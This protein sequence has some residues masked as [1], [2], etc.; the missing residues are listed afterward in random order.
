MENLCFKIDGIL[1]LETQ[2]SP[3]SYDV[4]RWLLLERRPD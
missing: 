1:R 3:D 2:Q 4:K